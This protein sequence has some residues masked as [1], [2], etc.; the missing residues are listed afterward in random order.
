MKKT[1]RS[2]VPNTIPALVPGILPHQA[3]GNQTVNDA[4]RTRMCAGSR[5]WLGSTVAL[6]TVLAV[7]FARG[8]LGVSEVDGRG[9]RIDLPAAPRRIVSIAPST[10]EILFALGLSGR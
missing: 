5:V 4:R 1:R 7:A 9:K 8:D 2:L 10:T 3:S 6:L